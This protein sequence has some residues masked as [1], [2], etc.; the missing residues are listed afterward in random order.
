M[1]KKFLLEASLVYNPSLISARFCDAYI[2]FSVT[3]PGSGFLWGD[4]YIAVF[5][6]C[7]APEDKIVLFHAHEDHDR[8]AGLVELVH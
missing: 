7:E 8:V 6:C 5:F 3:C 1:A 2:Y 4:G